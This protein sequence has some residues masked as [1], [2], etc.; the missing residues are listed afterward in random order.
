MLIVDDEDDIRE[1]PRVSLELVGQ[2]EVL[3]AA[4]GSLRKSL[5]NLCPSPSIGASPY[6]QH[7]AARIGDDDSGH[8]AEQPNVQTVPFHGGR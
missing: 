6:D 4:S 8:R 2:F 7:R 1:V 3:T 5:V